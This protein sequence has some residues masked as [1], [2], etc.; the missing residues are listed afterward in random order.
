MSKFNAKEI[1]E[2]NEIIAEITK[3]VKPKSEIG[4]RDRATLQGLLAANKVEKSPTFFK[5]RKEYSDAIVN[6]FVR[7]KK[8]ARNKFHTASQ[9]FVYVI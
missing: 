1:N 3:V 7:E 8:I 9:G 4:A 6:H 2:I 5:C